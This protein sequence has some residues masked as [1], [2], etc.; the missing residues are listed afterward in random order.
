MSAATF[1]RGGMVE[2]ST[3]P[4]AP[5]QSALLALGV[6]T[7]IQEDDIRAFPAKPGSIR[8]GGTGLEV[9]FFLFLIIFIPFFLILLRS[10]ARA[11]S[12]Y[13][14]ARTLSHT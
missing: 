5:H 11:R 7:A 4:A 9:N 3:H 14:Y 13:T 8:V 2:P 10:C 6:L 12:F 1:E